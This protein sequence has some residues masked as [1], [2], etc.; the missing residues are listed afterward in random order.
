MQSPW[1]AL[2]FELLQLRWWSEERPDAD[3]LDTTALE[4][5]IQ[6]EE[7]DRIE[8]LDLKHQF[9][10]ES[11]DALKQPAALKELVSW[12]LN[13]R[14]TEAEAVDLVERFRRALQNPRPT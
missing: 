5:I 11:A 13:Y 9:L 3:K 12:A 6:A 7:V 8:L 4:A 14:V 2:E 1:P 10:R